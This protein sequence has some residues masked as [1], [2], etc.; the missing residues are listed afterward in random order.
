MIE[1]VRPAKLPSQA[2]ISAWPSGTPFTSW[3]H[4]RAALSA[5]ST[6]SAPVFIGSTMA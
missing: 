2:M 1:I 5:V 6:A 3:A 4:L